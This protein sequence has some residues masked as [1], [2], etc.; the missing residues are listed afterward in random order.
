MKSKNVILVSYPDNFRQ[1]EAR[2]LI[3]SVS[4]Y[5]IVK[6]F[7]QKYLDHSMYGLGPGKVEEIKEFLTENKSEYVIFVDEHLS[8]R[9]M[10]NLEK[11]TE[12]KVIDRERLIL[13]IF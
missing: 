7:T 4:D 12:L 9:Q 1:Q 5:Q 11:A 6:T 10:Y 8:A 3:E 2:S 13:D